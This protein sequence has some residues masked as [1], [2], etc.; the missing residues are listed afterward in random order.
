MFDLQGQELA[1]A[2]PNE[3]LSYIVLFNE[4]SFTGLYTCRSV[5][6]DNFKKNTYVFLPGITDKT[7]SLI[8]ASQEVEVGINGQ[9]SVLLPCR[10]S[11]KSANV[12]LAQI[13]VNC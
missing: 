1:N 9:E 13:D 12:S 8:D 7:Q 4:V 3:F 5:E 2:E 11:K 10:V 6:D